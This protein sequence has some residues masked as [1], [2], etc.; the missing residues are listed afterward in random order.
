MPL[1]PFSLRRSASVSNLPTLPYSSSTLPPPASNDQ[2]RRS[3]SLFRRRGSRTLFRLP[4]FHGRQASQSTNDL[5]DHRITPFGV[6]D[7]YD[8]DDDDNDDDDQTGRRRR[9]M[10][11]T[12]TRYEGGAI[13]PAFG[14]RLLSSREAREAMRH[15]GEVETNE[16]VSVRERLA[17]A[18]GRGGP[19]RSLTSP[20]A[21]AA[22]SH[23][24]ADDDETP[25]STGQDLPKD[26]AP[27]S[28]PRPPRRVPVP[29]LD[30]LV[31]QTTSPLSLRRDP[32]LNASSP[33][34]S[35]SK[36]LP[37]AKEDEKG[38]AG[39]VKDKKRKP[40]PIAGLN[41]HPPSSENGLES[42]K[43]GS[44]GAASRRR[45]D[46]AGSTASVTKDA[47]LNQFGEAIKKERR[48][49]ELFE[50]ECDKAKAE[51]QEIEQN[52]VVMREKFSTLLDQQELTIRNLE[53]EIEE[54]ETELATAN[55]LDEATAREYFELLS[56]D[57][58]AALQAIES[59]VTS[60]DPSFFRSS[61]DPPTSGSTTPP[62]NPS[63]LSA[64][65]L[66]RGLNLRRRVETH[67][68]AYDTVG[69]HMAIPKPPLPNRS[70]STPLRTASG[71]A[72][73][74][75][76]LNGKLALPTSRPPVKTPRPRKLSRSRSNS[77]VNLRSDSNGL[78]ARPPPPPP[79]P[80]N[81]FPTSPDEEKLEPKDR[82]AIAD[83]RHSVS[84]L[85][86][87]RPPPISGVNAR[88]YTLDHGKTTPQQVTRPGHR[89]ER[90]QAFSAESDSEIDARPTTGCG[91][92]VRKRSNSF[93]TG[94]AGTMRVLFPSNA[95]KA[96]TA[97]V[98]SG[99]EGINSWLKSGPRDDA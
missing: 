83:V 46:S 31:P 37:I 65:S 26:Q 39:Q 75:N 79:Q 23:H 40:P 22:P 70:V 10:G 96:S 87:K 60:F 98:V 7:R 97:G 16:S 36:T 5:P 67:I 58:L 30:G 73:Q 14:A 56:A 85:R 88:S 1:L 62:P 15:A 72:G 41:Q 49:A 80:I 4:T 25:T 86:P 32:I 11:Q 53:A 99:G 93:K 57:S 94:F 50:G 12:T 78:P 28:P 77:N 2:P 44:G 21:A 68:A 45:A 42:S 63:K 3:P 9:E 51:L 20:G 38:K 76:Q 43:L 74:A 81:L 82:P 61:D 19:T 55:D 54:L 92:R 71:V 84:P 18:G 34:N 8:D 89:F 24:D 13:G 69:S 66:K 90:R 91:G 59:P 29:P 27:P 33:A 17:L 48:R 35:S 64:L 95:P 6:D 47:V 52:L